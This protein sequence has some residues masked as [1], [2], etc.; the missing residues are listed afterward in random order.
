MEITK[1]Y[2]LNYFDERLDRIKKIYETKNYSFNIDNIN[3]CNKDENFMEMI[4]YYVYEIFQSKNLN[5]YLK[6]EKYYLKSG[7]F[8]VVLTYFIFK[9]NEKFSYNEPLELFIKELLYIDDDK[10]YTESLMEYFISTKLSELRDE[11]PNFVFTYSMIVED[12]IISYQDINKNFKSKH[13]NIMILMEKIEGETLYDFLL[14]NKYNECDVIN[15]ILQVILALNAVNQHFPFVHG[16]LHSRNIMVRKLEIEKI[17]RYK[18]LLNGKLV[19][20]NL[21]TEYSVKIIDFG[22]SRIGF[23]Q[24]LTQNYDIESINIRMSKILPFK[25]KM[26][27]TNINTSLT[28]DEFLYYFIYKSPINKYLDFS[29]LEISKSF[30]CNQY[31]IING[32]NPEMIDNGYTGN[33]EEDILNYIDNIFDGF[34]YLYN[35][36]VSENDDETIRVH[37]KTST[38]IHYDILRTKNVL[39]KENKDIIFEKRAI[40]E[41]KYGNAYKKNIDSIFQRLE[42]I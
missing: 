38:P 36:N 1:K 22:S 12:E 16:D 39:S 7:F 30:N 35:N 14:E 9:E 23:N 17:I 28:Y 32:K 8:P 42:I 18:V 27:L 10:L 21:K 6:L 33:I 26:A 37:I 40:F 11:I 15:I 5:K 25:I 20:I 31:L 4:G 3:I 34:E 2:I 13:R 41:K 24:T 29:D 19:Y